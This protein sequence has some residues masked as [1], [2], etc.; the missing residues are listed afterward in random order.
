LNYYTAKVHIFFYFAIQLQIF[1]SLPAAFPLLG[2]NFF[3]C[4]S[5]KNQ[6][7]ASLQR[8]RTGGLVLQR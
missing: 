7:A 6:I 3:S 1:S 4:G 2:G 8:P 5:A